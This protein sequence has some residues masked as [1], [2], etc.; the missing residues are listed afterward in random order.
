MSFE[1]DHVFLWADEEATGAQRLVDLGFLEGAG[2]EQPGLGTANRRFVFNNGM[3]DFRWVKGQHEALAGGGGR[4]ALLDRWRKRATGACPFGLCLRPASAGDRAPPFS[5][6]TY[7]PGFLPP[8]RYMHVDDGSKRVDLPLLIFLPFSER[9]DWARSA[10]KHPSGAR[11]ITA[12][13]LAGPGVAACGERL[14]GAAEAG[15]D[16]ADDEAYLMDLTLDDRASGITFDLRP[17][18]PLRLA[19]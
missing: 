7:R 6:W 5:G 15:I 12:V 19:W 8:D 16:F 4:L 17:E 13:R 14:P 3:L 9:S 10:P 1:I 2:R 18:L 11:A